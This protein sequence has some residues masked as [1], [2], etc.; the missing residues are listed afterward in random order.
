MSS[1]NPPAKE[2]S[3]E[4]SSKGAAV[5]SIGRGLIIRTPAGAL[6]ALSAAVAIV[7]FSLTSFYSYSFLSAHR[8]DIATEKAESLER[9]L[10]MLTDGMNVLA[11]QTAHVQKLLDQMSSLPTGSRASLEI[12]KL[13]SDSAQ[14]QAQITALNA[15]ILDSPEKAVSLPLL[16]KDIENLKTSRETELANI[17]NEVSRL[18]DLN[19]WVIGLMFA[20]FVSLLGLAVANLFQSRRTQAEGLTEPRPLKTVAEQRN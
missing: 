9:N 2:A 11:V 17:H 13:R 20:F 5:L 4:P 10:L 8:T 3:S 14:L 7:G 6:S 1:A 12:S 18:Y 16:R 19:K 15:A